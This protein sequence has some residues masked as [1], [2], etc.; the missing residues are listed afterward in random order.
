MDVLSA[1][2]LIRTYLDAAEWTP[3]DPLFPQGSV[4]IT[5]GPE[6]DAWINLIPPSC[7]IG[8]GAARNDP[9]FS[10]EPG[11]LFQTFALMVAASVQNDALGEA[12]LIG[13]NIAGGD[14]R[15]LLEVEREVFRIVQVLNGAEGFNLQLR[16]MSG[17]E[18]F[19][20]AES[21][22]ISTR[23]YSYEGIITTT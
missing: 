8:I 19:W 7:M 18:P 12:S 17:V 13:A 10:E 5:N 11:L 22:Y 9:E 14:G 15:G 23:S 3:G 1:A 16:G 20:D 21:G 2:E 6:R 4:V